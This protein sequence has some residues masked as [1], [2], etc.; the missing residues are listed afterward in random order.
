MRLVLVNHMHPSTSHVSGMRAWYFARELAARGHQVVLI[1]EWREGAEST[2]EPERLAGLLRTHDWV[3]PLLLAIKPHPHQTLGRIRSSRT[4]VFLRKI[5]V[6]WNYLRHSGM[7]T[8]FSQGVQPYLPVLAHELHPQ[9]VW[10]VFGNTDCWL[11]AQRLARLSGCPWVADMKD[12]WEVFMRRPLQTLIARRFRD[13]AASTANAEFNARVLTCWFPPKPVVV[14]SGVDRCFLETL[15][16]PLDTGVFRLT[17]TGSV[18]DLK[19]LDIFVAGLAGWL[20]SRTGDDQVRAEV[21]YAGGDVARVQPALNR[22]E[23]MARVA[24][25]SYLS[26]PDLAALCR[27]ATINAY[28]W[29]PKTFHHKLLELL[30][31]SRPVLA[32]PGET[33]ESQ[34]LATDSG[35]ELYCCASNTDLVSTFDFIRKRCAAP[36][37]PNMGWDAFTWGTQALRLEQV[38]QQLTMQRSQA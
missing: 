16:V 2:L 28:I 22:L 9:A 23:G 29:N 34:R 20:A 32:F 7:F 21:I 27:S 5:L 24:L 35:G 10:G 13:M 6:S 3:E 36:I 15:P 25:Y 37:V 30:S 12:S 11:I 19:N 14:Y 4:P 26:L 33:E 8:D 17:L 38:F 18:Y 1:S 31:C